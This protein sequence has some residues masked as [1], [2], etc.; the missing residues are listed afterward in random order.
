V[1]G[2]MA[3]DTS[4]T[5]K[6]TKAAVTWNGHFNIGI[7]DGAYTS[8]HAKQTFNDLRI[9]GNSF[10]TA[11][12]QDVFAIKNNLDNQSSN[13]TDGDTAAATLKFVTGAGW[14]TDHDFYIPGEDN[15]QPGDI[16]VTAV[17]GNFAWGT[18]NILGQTLQ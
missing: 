13:T 4:G 15:D 5:V 12:S 10:V 8:D 11:A 14:D 3:V 1:T 18:L 16:P 17:T 9:E 7:N 6:T 2:N